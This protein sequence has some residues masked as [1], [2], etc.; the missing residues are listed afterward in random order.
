MILCG[1]IFVHRNRQTNTHVNVIY[2]HT[3]QYTLHT[4]YYNTLYNFLQTRSRDGITLSWSLSFISISIIM[5]IFYRIYFV[6]LVRHRVL[7]YG[8]T[9]TFNE[10]YGTIY[11]R[12]V[13]A[14]LI[15]GINLIS[16]ADPESFLKFFTRFH[17]KGG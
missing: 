1:G 7:Y 16:A 2:I 10:F 15:N 13:K 8:V 11:L 6:K 3:F 17:K 4:L 5:C 14:V 9:L 12:T